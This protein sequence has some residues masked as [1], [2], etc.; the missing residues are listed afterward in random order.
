MTVFRRLRAWL[1][2]SRLDAELREELAQHTAWKTESLMADG[3]DRQEAHRRAAIAVGNVTKYRESARGVW[4][5][6]ALD[7]LVQDIRYGVRVLAKSPAFT[8]FAV[9][10]L[11]VGIGAGAAVFSLADAVLLRTMAVRDPASLV[12]MRWRSGPVFPFSSLSGNG[13]QNTA[14]LAS[15]SFSY[16]AYQSFRTDA[17]RTLD[18]LGFADLYRGQRRDRRPR[19]ACI[20]A[21]GLRQLLRRARR[22]SGHRA[23]TWCHR[24]PRRCP[25]RRGYQRSLLEAAIRQQCGRR[26]KSGRRQRDSLHRRRNRAG[27]VSRDRPGRKRSR[28]LPSRCRFRRGSAR[29]TAIPLPMPTSGGC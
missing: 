15:T 3:L 28:P 20:S 19:R 24:Q 11:A 6:Q 16:A 29:L 25:S 23:G 5:F 22:C 26:R 21:R 2:R 7:S 12:L 8:G 9:A 14:G 17:S 10:S 27:D 13:E 18:V 4:G 1:R